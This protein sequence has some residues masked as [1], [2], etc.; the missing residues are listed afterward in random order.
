M[1]IPRLE[2]TISKPHVLGTLF[3]LRLGEGDT[4][5][6]SLIDIFTKS[7][8]LHLTVLVAAF[9]FFL[10]AGIRSVKE[11]EPEGFLYL[12]LAIFFFL[13]HLFYIANFPSDSPVA[14]PFNDWSVWNWM[15]VLC[16]PALVVLYLTLGAIHCLFYRFRQGAY[17]L[18]FG[19]SLACYVWMLGGE[20]PLDVRAILT[21][22]WGLTFF[23]LELNPAL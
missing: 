12:T 10:M 6:E 2:P 11:G 3:T 20:W 22:V 19:A 14:N 9:L 7:A 21:V 5:A 1:I 23:K 15:V 16:A 8:I 17:N 18:F 4:M 13:I